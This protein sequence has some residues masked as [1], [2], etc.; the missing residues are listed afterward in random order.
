MAVVVNG[1]VFISLPKLETFWMKLCGRPHSQFSHKTAS[2]PARNGRCRSHHTYIFDTAEVVRVGKA[3]STVWV[4]G[5]T[6]QGHSIAYVL[7]IYVQIV[8]KIQ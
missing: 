8:P 5:A 6:V 2:S 1:A 4:T 3:G 7:H